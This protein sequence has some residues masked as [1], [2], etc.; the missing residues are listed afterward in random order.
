[1]SRTDTVILA[2]SLA[3]VAT[4]AVWQW[5]PA[6]VGAGAVVWLEGNAVHRLDLSRDTQV[7]VEG[8]AGVTEVQVEAGRV[9]VAASPGPR[10]ICVRAGWMESPGETA[11]CLPNRVVVE[12]TGEDPRF[13]AINQ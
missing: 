9:R 13:D 5:R 6:G 11:V 3:L 10:Q 2:L 4:L 7:R 12:V 1:M 8:P